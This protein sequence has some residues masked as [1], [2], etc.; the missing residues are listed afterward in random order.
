MKPTA[1]RTY[2]KPTQGTGRSPSH[3]RPRRKLNARQRRLVMLILEGSTIQEAAAELGVSKPTVY[4]WLAHPDVSAELHSATQAALQAARNRLTATV[5][6]AAEELITLS[7]EARRDDMARVKALELRL[8]RSGLKPAEAV[9][10]R[11]ATEVE[12]LSDEELEAAMAAIV[13]E[14]S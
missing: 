13:R 2:G 6:E 11:V 9:E 5:C 4:D 14:K 10:L 3:Q 12:Q 1:S 8:D 7:K